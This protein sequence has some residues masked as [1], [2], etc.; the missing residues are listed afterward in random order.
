MTSAARAGRVAPGSSVAIRVPR[1]YAVA[2]GLALAYTGRGVSGPPLFLL[3]GFPLDH[4]MWQGQLEGLGDLARVIAPDLPGFGQT[5]PTSDGLKAMTMEAYADTVV[6]LA[7]ALGFSRFVAGGLSMGGYIALALA[8]RYPERL[9]GLLLCDTR[10]EE[11][12]PES[13]RNRFLDADTVLAEGLSFLV[14]KHLRLLLS[15][16]TLARKRDQVNAVEAMIRR[17]SWGGVAAALRGMAERQDSW[18]LLSRIA[19]PTLVMVGSDDVVTPP[20][21]ARQMAQAI[22]GAEFAVVPGAGHLSPFEMP[23]AANVAIRKLLRRVES[24]R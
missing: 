17:A 19:V 2:V 11:D 20:D 5:P 8:R 13:K 16:E 9:S 6:S 7:D 12:S 23:N 4:T 3:H 24:G 15:P 14:Q 1:R 10:A 21:R 18:A 22:P